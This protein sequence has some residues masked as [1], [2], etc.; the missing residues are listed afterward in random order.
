MSQWLQWRGR[1]DAVWVRWTGRI[2]RITRNP[3]RRSCFSAGRRSRSN[4]SSSPGD[5][6]RPH[7]ERHIFDGMF[8]RHRRDLA[9]SLGKVA[10]V[11]ALMA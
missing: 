7:D 10:P 2:N 4:K 8:L 6:L 5:R 9:P 11:H 1:W 3:G